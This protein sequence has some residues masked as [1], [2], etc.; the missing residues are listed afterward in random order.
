[1]VALRAAASGAAGASGGGYWR[2]QGR[3][4]VALGV[5]QAVAGVGAVLLQG[6]GSN[7]AWLL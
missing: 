6:G 1:M 3:A 4:L 2:V 7:S 5:V